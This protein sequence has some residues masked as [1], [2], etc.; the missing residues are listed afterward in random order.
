MREIS[1]SDVWSLRAAVKMKGETSVIEAQHT[2]EASFY[3]IRRFVHT[4]AENSNNW[5]KY[6]I[7]ILNYSKLCKNYMYLENKPLLDCNIFKTN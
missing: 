4:T 2:F 3:D 1:R 6:C 7:E 5:T